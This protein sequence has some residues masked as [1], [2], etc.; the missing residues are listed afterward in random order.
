MEIEEITSLMREFDFDDV[1]KQQSREYLTTAHKF[2]SYQDKDDDK[3][4]ITNGLKRFINKSDKMIYL[5]EAINYLNEEL[6]Q[7]VERIDYGLSDTYQYSH[8]LANF[9]I[10]EREFI[11]DNREL[12]LQKKRCETRIFY[13][14][15][16]LE[17]LG[18]K[19][20]DKSAFTVSEVDDLT[21]KINALLIKIDELS[22]GQEVIFN[23]IEEL[24]A[25][26]KEMMADFPLGK[27]R[28]QQRFVGII[29]S[30]ISNKGADVIF[31]QI[32]PELIKIIKDRI[33][34]NLLH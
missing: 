16:E 8:G 33:I 32:K 18:L 20:L 23:F 2:V 12:K 1:I 4:Y 31:D 19:N 26:L 27:K 22:V 28:W 5:V 34:T 7:T 29:A 14:V 17:K 24:K 30:Y 15:R 6:S 3:K 11:Q 25:D 21:R 13:A 10:Y 9:S